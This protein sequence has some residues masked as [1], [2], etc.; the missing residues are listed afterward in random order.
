MKNNFLIFIFSLMTLTLQAQLP[1][2]YLE[3]TENQN[4]LITEIKGETLTIV[5]FW[6]TWCKPCLI[7][8]PELVKIQKEFE[9]E[10]VQLIGINIDSPRNKSKIRP[11]ANARGLNYPV[12][13]DENQE[14]MAEMNVVLVPTLI[15]FDKDGN[16][17]FV[18][19]GFVPGDQD[20]IREKIVE[21]LN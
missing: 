3:N 18:H 1:D 7:A 12:L 21:F 20:I 6:A 15:I 10:G 14:M 17:V 5:D 11:F 2:I 8:I 4:V 13:L 16:Q 19:E 9:S